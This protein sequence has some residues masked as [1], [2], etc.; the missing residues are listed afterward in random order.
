MTEQLLVSF[1]KLNI[2]K[3]ESNEIEGYNIFLRNPLHK[4]D[5][6]HPAHHM[7]GEKLSALKANTGYMNYK[8]QISQRSFL[9]NN[10][11]FQ[12]NIY[13]AKKLYS[14]CLEKKY[15]RQLGK[16]FN[17]SPPWLVDDKSKWLMV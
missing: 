9:E 13:N 14:Q 1:F 6:L 16:Y 15:Q 10:P 4:A 12:C 8:V 5:L 17:C 7:G 2:L 3:N 11:N